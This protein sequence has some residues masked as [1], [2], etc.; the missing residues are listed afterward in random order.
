M[1]RF[2]DD[3]PDADLPEQIDLPADMPPSET[4][5]AAAEAGA[6]YLDE[7]STALEIGP[8]HPADVRAM[9]LVLATARDDAV[10]VEH[11]RSGAAPVEPPPL[12]DDPLAVALGLVPAQQAALSGPALRTARQR[13]GMK[14][15]QL[16]KAVTELGHPLRPGELQR[17]ESTPSIPLSIGTIGALATVLG[18]STESLSETVEV[19]PA[20]VS[21]RRFHQLVERLAR[22]LKIPLVLAQTQLLAKAAAPARRGQ[23]YTDDHVLDALEQY[24]EEHE[25]RGGFSE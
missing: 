11:L 8:D 24:V 14:A 25:R 20:Y 22:C 19:P 4:A 16:A 12:D 17:W 5:A 7:P 23:G 6:R 13:K 10:A 9:V 3:R 2:D 15:S 1:S 21:S 18:A